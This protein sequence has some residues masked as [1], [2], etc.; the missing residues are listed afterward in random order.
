ME[1]MTTIE[2]FSRFLSRALNFLDSCFN[3]AI[4]LK[5]P[6]HRGLLIFRGGKSWSGSSAT[7]RKMCSQRLWTNTWG[8]CRRTHV[9]V[10]TV[11]PQ[12]SHNFS[13]NDQTYNLQLEDDPYV[14]DVEKSR[15][16]APRCC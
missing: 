14:T 2:L 7:A 9:T 5:T 6:A 11:T 15:R 3:Q 10:C 8:D 1:D 16:D 13:H 4:T 12:L